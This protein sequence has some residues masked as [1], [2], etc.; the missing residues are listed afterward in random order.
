LKGIS[1]VE[2]KAYTPR[3]SNQLERLV[4]IG[5]ERDLY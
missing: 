3:L 4:R 5:M 1:Y 2:R